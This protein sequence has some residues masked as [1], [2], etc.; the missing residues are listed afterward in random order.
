MLAMKKLL[1][2]ST[3]S[4]VLFVTVL[5][6]RIEI[7]QQ[8]KATA[9]F[10]NSYTESGSQD[11]DI[12]AP[13]TPPVFPKTIQKKIIANF[14]TEEREKYNSLESGYKEE[15]VTLVGQR[16]AI[17]AAQEILQARIDALKSEGA[18]AFEKTQRANELFDKFLEENNLDPEEFEEKY[19]D[20]LNI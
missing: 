18:D 17:Q 7:L 13:E 9:Y 20:L 6:F 2:I 16:K 1:L 12:S 19:S 15:M 8:V 4:I 5:I 3:F 10:V 11:Q 14:S